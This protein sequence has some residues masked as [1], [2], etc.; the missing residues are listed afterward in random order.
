MN[1]PTLSYSGT[2][3]VLEFCGHKTLFTVGWRHRKIRLIESNAKC[4]H[5]NKLTC[6]GTLRQVFLSEAPP[7]LGF[8]LGG[9]SFCRSQSHAVCIYCTT[10]LYFDTGKVGGA[11]VHQAGSK[12]QQ[13][14][15]VS[16]VIKSNKHPPQSSFTGHF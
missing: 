13:D 8:C 3:I 10:V 7:L 14:L 11:I 4:R 15:T 6:K 12:H 9:L 5:L 2:R 16:P 1:N